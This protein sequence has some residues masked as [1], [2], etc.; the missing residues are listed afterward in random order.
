MK[1]YSLTYFLSQSVKSLFRNGVMTLASILALIGCLLVTGGFALLVKNINENLTDL[2]LQNEIVVFVDYDLSQEETDKIYEEIKNLDNVAEVEYIPKEE[3][4]REMSEKYSDEYNSIFD[5]LKEDN[6][7]ADAF[8]IKYEDNAR[9]SDLNYNLQKIEGVM[10]VNNR[11]D[12]SMKI[13]NMKSGVSFIFIWFLVLLFIVSLFVI[14]NTI[15]LSVFSRRNE[16]S[17]MRYIGATKAFVITPFVIEGI[18]IGLFSSVVSYFAEWYMY[19]YIQN[20]L[21]AEMSFI[22]I[23]EFSS[24]SHWVLLGFIGIGIITGIIGSCISLNKY[25]NT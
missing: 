22:K 19:S 4:L 18:I 14:I 11:V 20:S 13:E 3:G 23:I 12:L 1:R 2:G 7:F 15:K 17:I 8:N 21:H 10:K 16:I 24:V 5:V 6:P 9:V 25:L